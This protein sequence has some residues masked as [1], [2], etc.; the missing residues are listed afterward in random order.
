MKNNVY[1]IFDSQANAAMMPIYAQEDGFVI[2]EFIRAV[3]GGDEKMTEFKED[4]VLY[5]IATWDDESMQ[6]GDAELTRV[7]SGIE[8]QKRSLMEDEQVEALRKQVEALQ[9]QIVNITKE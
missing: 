9:E 6:F 7:I 8:A 3:S 5:R 2:R 1:V 4:F